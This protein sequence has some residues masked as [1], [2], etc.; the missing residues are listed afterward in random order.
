MDTASYMDTVVGNLY[1]AARPLLLPL[2]LGREEVSIE[3]LV[4]H[5]CR[6]GAWT[7]TYSL[8]K[9]L[10]AVRA[11]P[12]SLNE[13]KLPMTVDPRRMP[14]LKRFIDVG[15][16]SLE[17]GLV[18]EALHEAYKVVAH[19]QLT[20]AVLAI[21]C[22]GLQGVAALLEDR[23]LIKAALL[24][25][26][27][28]PGR[29]ELVAGETSVNELIKDVN[30]R[31]DL[32]WLLDE[33]EG[34][35]RVVLTPIVGAAPRRL[36]EGSVVGVSVPL[37]VQRVPSMFRRVDFE[38]RIVADLGCGYG[39]K[40]A[41]AIARGASNVLFIDLYKPYLKRRR[42]ALRAERIVADVRHLPLKDGAVEVSILWN[43]LQFVAD[44][45]EVLKEVRRVT[46]ERALVSVY[47]ASPPTRPEGEILC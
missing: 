44:K 26:C 22:V 37:K 40:G 21:A 47:N 36:A 9:G 2:V 7:L 16:L 27:I 13:R 25:R 45:D 29:L 46:R 11:E 15:L 17:R 34:A 1:A 35:G 20:K 24:A 6:G 18:R 19:T 41:Y 39:V 30:G 38:G 14:P 10:V 8:S 3:E 33:L 31:V 5:C 32:E 28:F 4:E 42:G 12:G 43:V 23:G